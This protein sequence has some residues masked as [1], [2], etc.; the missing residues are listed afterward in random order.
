MVKLNLPLTW[1]TPLG[2][3]ITQYYYKSKKT[4]IPLKFAGKTKKLI[5][6]EWTD[7]MNKQK[8]TQAIIPNIIHSLDANHL[9]NIVNFIN[10]EN[11][12]VNVITIHDCFGTHPNHMNYLEFVVRKEFILLY[13]NENFLEKFHNRFL[14]TLD[15]N[16]IPITIDDKT[17]ESL[18][19]INNRCYKIPQLPKLG[20]LDLQKIKDAK[21]M[22]C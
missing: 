17:L 9:I 3:K 6:R 4:L 21:Y 8:Q 13:S 18:V 2:I 1:F 16:Q 12:K 7:I 11:P 14:Q 15:D 20:N 10:K 19:E 22:I 5:I